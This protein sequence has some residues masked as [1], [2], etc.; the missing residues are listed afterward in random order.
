MVPGGVLSAVCAY[1][2]AVGSCHEVHVNLLPTRGVQ[3][4]APLLQI[5]P[6]SSRAEAAHSRQAAV[7]TSGSGALS[8]RS[9][10]QRLAP[11]F[12]SSS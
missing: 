6:C 11:A 7:S 10:R 3:P 9:D 4:R 8:S 12:L 5:A 2:G 1:A